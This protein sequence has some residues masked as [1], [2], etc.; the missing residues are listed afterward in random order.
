MAFVTEPA[1]PPYDEDD[2][3]DV[4]DDGMDNGEQGIPQEA[5]MAALQRQLATAGGPLSGMDPQ[6]LLQFAMRMAA[7]ESAG[8]DVAG[9]MAEAILGGED[10]G[11]DV[12]DETHNAAEEELLTWI[13]KQRNGTSQ[14][15]P[16]EEEGMMEETVHQPPTP[17]SSDLKRSVHVSEA[18]T[19]SS[20]TLSSTPDV[21]TTKSS[22]KRKAQEEPSVEGSTK[23]LKKRATRSFDAPTASSQAKTAS[24]R[25]T[26]RSKPGKRK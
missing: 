17:P 8:D 13:A 7:D 26:T 9:E 18:N 25:P 1:S 19:T 2:D 10:D 5:L 6:Q 24:S 11:D 14:G 21:D 15:T 22:L 12:D 3:G 4:E 16:Y 23:A 20:N